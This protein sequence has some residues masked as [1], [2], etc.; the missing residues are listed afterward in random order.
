MVLA[1]LSTICYGDRTLNAV[2]FY[3]KAFRGLFFLEFDANTGNIAP[4]NGTGGIGLGNDV[5]II[6][7]Q[8]G[9]PGNLDNPEG[10]PG[11]I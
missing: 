3:L 9:N 6:T 10:N 2:F 8:F 4:G 11:G 1:C 5:G 7:E